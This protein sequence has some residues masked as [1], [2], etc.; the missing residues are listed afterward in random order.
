MR[1]SRGH[2]E[3]TRKKLVEGGRAIAKK[4]GFDG[5]GIDTLMASIGLTGGAFYNHFPSKAALFRELIE[6]ELE[7]SAQMLAG[8]ENSP[9]DH[10][11]K[12]LR[13]YLSTAHAMNPETG[14]ALPTLGAEIARAPVDVR[15]LVEDAL[16]RV[17][18][19][20]SERLEDKDDAWALIAQCVGAIVL[21]R[22]VEREAT[23]KEI[24]RSSRQFIGK[25][26]ATAPGK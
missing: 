17:E 8:D 13:S 26:P 16:K 4:G 24:L 6:R 12:R 25:K 7:N 15:L 21:A 14:C 1:Y 10:V 23:R 2:K 20:W 18:K 19:S 22:V 11:A 3:E 5:T 9:S